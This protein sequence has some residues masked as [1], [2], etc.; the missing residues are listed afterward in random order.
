MPRTTDRQIWIGL[1]SDLLEWL[2]EQPPWPE[3]DE[4]FDFLLQ[5]RDRA[6]QNRYFYRPSRYQRRTRSL[7]ALHFFHEDRPIDRTWIRLSEYEFGRLLDRVHL[8]PVF[9]PRQGRPQAPVSLQMAVFLHKLGHNTSL[10][11]TASCFRISGK[12]P[13]SSTSCRRLI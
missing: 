12:L 8:H 6:H 7:S 2:A 3:Y 11:L 10:G 9:Q 1:L 4:W 5:L 13:A